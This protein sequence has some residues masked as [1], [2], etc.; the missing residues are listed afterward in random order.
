M[1]RNNFMK[2]AIQ[3]D[4][5]STLKPAGDS[6]IVLLREAAAR[7]MEV[8]YYHH[9]TLRW[10]DG[11]VYAALHHL[12]VH[13]GDAWFTLGEASVRPLSE[14]DVVLMRQDPPF[15]MGYITATYL[16]ER[17]QGNTRVIND[18]ASVRSYP[19]KLLPLMMEESATPESLITA[20]SEDI[21]AFLATHKDIILKPLYG[22][23]G[24]AVLRL[25]EG[26]D[27]VQALLEMIR[28]RDPLPVIAQSFLPAVESQDIRVVL[29][30][31]QIAGAFARAPALG[32][33]RANMRVG[34]TPIAYTLNAKQRR[35]CERIA[36]MLD[37]MG[38]HMAGV[39]LIGDHLTEINVTSPTGLRTLEKLYHTSPAAMFWDGVE[40]H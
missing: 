13:D 3:M 5:P 27:N 35:T 31:G 40:S 14:M 25:R 10:K 20:D 37:D 21:L 34:G 24:H 26:G 22:F 12:I 6:T 29:I 36:P 8:Y 9:T 1:I 18:P 7:G 16:L 33:I 23:G 4:P 11:D 19:E 17:I 28:L 15:D 32:E 38:L 39:D 30:H 2:I